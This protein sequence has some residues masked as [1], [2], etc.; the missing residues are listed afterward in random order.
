ISM[1][2]P[3]FIVSNMENE[4]KQRMENGGYNSTSNRLTIFVLLSLSLSSSSLLVALLRLVLS[5]DCILEVA[6][7]VDRVLLT[8]PLS[9]LLPSCTARIEGSFINLSRTCHSSHGVLE[10]TRLLRENS[11]EDFFRLLL[12]STHRLDVGSELSLLASLD[13][14]LLSVDLLLE[15]SKRSSGST[16]SV[17]CH[18]DLLFGSLRCFLRQ[19]HSR[20]VIRSCCL[21]RVLQLYVSG[22]VLE[23]LSLVLRHS[24]LLGSSSLLEH[25]DVNTSVLRDLDAP[26]LRVII[27][28]SVSPSGLPLATC[29]VKHLHGK[30]FS[31]RNSFQLCVFFPLSGCSLFGNRF[32]SGQLEDGLRQNR[33]NAVL[34]SFLVQFPHLVEQE[35]DVV[36]GT[37]DQLVFIPEL[38]NWVP[39]DEQQSS[40]IDERINNFVDHC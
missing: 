33:D 3:T 24:L 35:L 31:G 2:L 9:S 6:R 25:I 36:P 22:H 11:L 10:K 28:S 30:V 23:S 12:L 15:L 4:T 37:S 5:L 26:V 38:C 8:D 17:Y 1:K 40:A 18:T 16:G 34:D 20:D 19:S 7:L 14:L 13:I 21:L 32:L 27:A 39:V 29:L